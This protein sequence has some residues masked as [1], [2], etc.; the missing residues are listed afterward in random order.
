MFLS[1]VD[2]IL[3]DSRYNAIIYLINAKSLNTSCYLLCTISVVYCDISYTVHTYTW[4]NLNIII[5]MIW[6][7]ISIQLICQAQCISFKILN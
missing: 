2:D 3:F 5:I 6:Y 7:T 1:I 4:Y